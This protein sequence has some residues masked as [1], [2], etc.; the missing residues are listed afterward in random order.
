MT[1]V[2]CDAKYNV[3]G[4][5]RHLAQVVEEHRSEGDLEGYYAL[6]VPESDSSG[7]RLELSLRSYVVNY[8]PVRFS[9]AWKIYVG[10]EMFDRAVAARLKPG[11]A[12]HGFDGSS[13]R[14]FLRAR[15]LRYE[16]LE[17]EGGMSHIL[18]VRRLWKRACEMYPIEDNP[19]HP[20]QV[21]R[22]LAEYEMAE[23]IWV[24]SEYSR[25]TFLAEGVP[26]SKL[27]RRHLVIP[28]RYR[29]SSVR[30]DDGVFRLLNTGFL[31]PAKGVPLLVEVFRRL[32][33]RAELTFV[34][35]AWSRGMRKFMAQAQTSDPRIRV[36]Q[37][38][39]LPYLQRA[40]VYVHPSFQEGF[41]YA[42]MEALL[43]GVPVVV[44]EDTG[45]KEHVREGV[46]GHIVPTGNGEAI[47]ETL[48]SM[49]QKPLPLFNRLAMNNPIPAV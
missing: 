38:D 26:A 21:R 19:L 28:E 49:M 16:R 8:T 47:L 22:F 3:G 39:P 2:A 12:F 46:N 17:M 18:N 23:I 37:G 43:C 29:P 45:M 36:V 6:S 13:M 48:K 32:P 11:A 40:D 42:P 27:R 1:F 9:T 4:L 30:T 35:N 14:T 7:H 24:S 31:S 15:R 20:A 25:Q 10:S 41:G 5:G 34:G 33:G 44:T